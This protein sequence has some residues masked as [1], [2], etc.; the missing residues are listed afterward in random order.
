MKRIMIVFAA[1][2]IVALAGFAVYLSSGQRLGPGGASGPVRTIGEALVGGPFTLTDHTGKRVTDNDF[3]GRYMLVYF[4]YTWCP[5]VCPTE[6]QVIS[7]ALDNLGDKAGQIRPIFVTVDPERDTVAQMADYVANFHASMVGLTGSPE[8]IAAV[9]KAYRVY[10]AKAKTEG[11]DTDYAVDHGSLIYLMDPEGKF[12]THF[13]YGTD[14][15]KLAQGLAK[16]IG[17]GS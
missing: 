7:A 4:G 6:L 9:A 3:R 17:G 2:T 10:Y 14:P 1:T 5:D 12:V 11:S 8:E 15:E 13:T 16:A